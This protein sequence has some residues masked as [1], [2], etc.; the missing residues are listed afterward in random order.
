MACASFTATDDHP[1]LC[2]CGAYV[3]E[4]LDF[5]GDGDGDGDDDD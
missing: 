1:N 3:S 4:H 5:S 2:T